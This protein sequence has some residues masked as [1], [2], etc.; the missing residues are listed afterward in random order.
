[1]LQNLIFAF[2]QMVGKMTHH[3]WKGRER[4]REGGREEGKKKGAF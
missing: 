2:T 1:M 3:K 4:G